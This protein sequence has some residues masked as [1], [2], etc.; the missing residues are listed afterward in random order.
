MTDSGDTTGSIYDPV[1][2]E[3]AASGS[4][5]AYVPPVVSTANTEVYIVQKGDILGR[6][7]V[8]FDTTTKTLISM[9]NLS[10][11]DVLYVGQELRVPA[12][13]LSSGGSSSTPKSYSSVKKGGEYT[14]Q[15]GDTLSG[16]AVAAGVSIGDLRSLNNITD[17]QIFAGKTLYIPSGGKVP[18]ST[19]KT[20][21]KK[22]ET[23]PEAPAPEVEPAPAPLAPAPVDTGNS[24]DLKA[25]IDHVVY[26]G[27]TLAD[28]ARQYG[29]SKSEIMRLNNISDESA[30]KE[31]QRLRIP[32]SE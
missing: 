7:A 4:P 19:Q 15:K 8:R 17:D 18:T 3:S 29:V 21:P 16:I 31:N 11:P 28:I 2:I 12:G 25:V 27:E 1:I 13:S 32:I 23:A 9:N 26:P 10:N 5:T 14:I 20:K 30:I 24:M 22:T 6:L